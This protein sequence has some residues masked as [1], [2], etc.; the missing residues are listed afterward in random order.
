MSEPAYR[1]RKLI[2]CNLENLATRQ[3]EKLKE[4]FLASETELG[5]IYDIKELARPVEDHRH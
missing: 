4:V 3:T 1:Y 2:T 5:I